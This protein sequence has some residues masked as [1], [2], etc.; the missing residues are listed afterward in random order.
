MKDRARVG[1]P[2]DGIANTASGLERVEHRLLD[3]VDDEGTGAGRPT[4][5]E[6]A[7]P[8]VAYLEGRNGLS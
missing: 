3:R 7:V 8:A 5:N 4:D 1:R 6:K 2:M